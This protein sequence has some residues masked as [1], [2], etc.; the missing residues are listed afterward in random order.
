MLENGKR[1]VQG[2]EPMLYLSSRRPT[3]RRTA[4]QR[5]SVLIISIT[6][7]CSRAGTQARAD[8]R[9]G[10][11][12]HNGFEKPSPTTHPSSAQLP[13]TR[14][15]GAPTNVLPRKQGIKMRGLPA[16]GFPPPFCLPPNRELSRGCPTPA[17]AAETAPAP[18]LLA[19]LL[20][21]A[22]A[23]Q[24]VM[25]GLGP[26]AAQRSAGPGLVNSAWR[27]PPASTALLTRR[28]SAAASGARVR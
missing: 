28:T 21:K 25:L 7:C 24:H 1:Q 2:A 18:P 5:T 4:H 20:A 27:R 3:G 10:R 13:N 16:T 6:R 22:R 15:A 17:G 23:R 26:S 12:R 9:P 11:P 8:P 14:T 19:L